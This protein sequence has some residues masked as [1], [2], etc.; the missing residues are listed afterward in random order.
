MS[1]TDTK[2]FVVPHDGTFDG[3]SSFFPSKSDSL[4]FRPDLTV[5]HLREFWYEAWMVGNGIDRTPNENGTP[6]DEVE[7][8]MLTATSI[9]GGWVVEE[10]VLDAVETACSVVNPG[11][12]SAAYAMNAAMKAVVH[13][14]A[15]SFIGQQPDCEQDESV[16]LVD[17]TE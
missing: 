16:D 2:L 3:D 14:L 4:A 1:S 7:D 6:N 12:D 5:K 17:D 11:S 8:A 13:G 10:R 9:V 15:I